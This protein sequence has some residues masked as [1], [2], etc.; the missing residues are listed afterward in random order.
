SG[1]DTISTEINNIQASS[2]IQIYPN[3]AN[4]YIYISSETYKNEKCLLELYNSTGT[5]VS[6]FDDVFV[7]ETIQLPKLNYGVYLAIITTS[8][9][10]QFSEKLVITE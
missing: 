4:E 5:L 2:A 10:K 9:G 6:R 1:C 7:N 8:S 3:P